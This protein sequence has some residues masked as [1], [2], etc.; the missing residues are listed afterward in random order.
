M[1]HEDISDYSSAKLGTHIDRE[2]SKIPYFQA[3]QFEIQHNDAN[4]LMGLAANVSNYATDRNQAHDDFQREQAGIHNNFTQQQID[5][6]ADDS[7]AYAKL[8]NQQQIAQGHDQTTMAR[9]GLNVDS[10]N[11]IAGNKLASGDEHFDKTL[12]FKK[13]SLE[14]HLAEQRYGTDARSA[15]GA[16]S[17]DQRQA[18]D[19]QRAADAAQRR[20]DAEAKQQHK[21][22]LSF[23]R[24]QSMA[25]AKVAEM[26][27]RS[28]DKTI[29][30][31]AWSLNNPQTMASERPAIEAKMN[32]AREMLHRKLDELK[33]HLQR[34]VPDP[35]QS[36]AVDDQGGDAPMDAGGDPQSA[37]YPQIQ[38]EQDYQ[39][40]QPGQHYTDP[41]GETR[42]KREAFA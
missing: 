18:R 15:T 37:N 7:L 28:L 26:E 34:S 13:E 23:V 14:G 32:A 2:D 5:N 25:A 24:S 4:L 40:L 41:N 20:Q 35:N 27:A 9:T 39:M 16:A 36:G 1:L 6:K 29:R 17:L 11:T 30:S 33:G 3:H 38:S 42:M 31:L 12:G 21:D 19:D 10:R 8:L 22:Q